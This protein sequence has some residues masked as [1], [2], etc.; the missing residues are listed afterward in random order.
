M[1]FCVITNVHQ[2]F[3]IIFTKEISSDLDYIVND[4]TTMVVFLLSM[5]MIYY[6]IGLSHYYW[7]NFD[8]WKNMIVLYK[9]L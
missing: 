8:L 4:K 9:S 2:T 1:I 6:A 5:R 3:Q 7:I